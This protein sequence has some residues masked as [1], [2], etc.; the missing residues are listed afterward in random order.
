MATAAL[1]LH[2]DDV[3]RDL[4]TQA[5]FPCIHI[6]MSHPSVGVRYAACQ[7]TRVLCRS[8]SVLRTSMVDWGM[9]N[10]LFEHIKNPEEDLRV[11]VAAMAGIC[12]L[13]NDYSPM[14]VV[15]IS[16]TLP[17]IS[18]LTVVHVVLVAIRAGSDLSN[19][20]VGPL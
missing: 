4:S 11:K 12:N 18:P 17:L 8:V 5:F 10:V 6:C 16:M 13:L 1:T 15:R 20:W 9:G 3:R 19:C 2:W 7:S 14:R